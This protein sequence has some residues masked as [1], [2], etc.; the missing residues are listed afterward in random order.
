MARP[1]LPL[2]PARALDR[3]AKSYLLPQIVFFHTVFL[4]H[5]SIFS[6]SAGIFNKL[7]LRD[8][9][10]NATLAEVAATAEQAQDFPRINIYANTRIKICRH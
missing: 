8:K 5:N 4:E 3:S 10:I 9:N 7:T 1:Q 2:P 6:E